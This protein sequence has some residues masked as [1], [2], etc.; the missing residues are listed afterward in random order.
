V[1]EIDYK[2]LLRKKKAILDLIK[3]RASNDGQSSYSK[4]ELEFLVLKQKAI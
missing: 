3:Q 1:P 4:D 2:Q